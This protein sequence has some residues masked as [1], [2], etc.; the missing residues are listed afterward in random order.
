MEKLTILFGT[1]ICHDINQD[2]WTSVEQ[3][4]KEGDYSTETIEFPIINSSQLAYAMDAASSWGDWAF[5]TG[6]DL[7]KFNEIYDKYN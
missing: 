7:E 5:L 1:D 6:S 4:V 2:D 3:R